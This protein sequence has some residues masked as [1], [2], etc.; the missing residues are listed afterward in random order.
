MDVKTINIQALAFIGDA[1]FS[2]YI[3]SKLLENGICNSNELQK[4]STYYVS[5]VGQVKILN[6]LLDNGYLKEEEI[7][8]IK[9][10]RNNKKSNHP[11]YTDVVTYKNST[12]FEALIG[13]LYLI[14]KDR[15]KE[16]LNLIEVT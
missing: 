5:A 4:K 10:G 1:V 16:I 6:Y 8:T 3:R 7:D 2:L 9:R 11:K 12:G 15:L 14:N 13:E